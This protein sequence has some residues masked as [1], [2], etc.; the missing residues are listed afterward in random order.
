MAWFQ[1]WSLGCTAFHH[2]PFFGAGWAVGHFPLAMTQ[3]KERWTW[4]QKG[5]IQVPALPLLYDLGQVA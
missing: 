5:Q 3:T 1:S 2:K 4:S